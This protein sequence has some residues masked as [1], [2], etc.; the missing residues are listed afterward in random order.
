MKHRKKRVFLIIHKKTLFYLMILFLAGAGL[1]IGIRFQMNSNVPVMGEASTII[2]RLLS[3][4]NA[5]V[6][7]RVAIIIDDF[8][9]SGNGTKEMTEINQ[10]LTCA[11]IP[12]LPYTKQDAELAHNGGHEVI[13]HIPMEPHIG[14]PKW[15]GEK[16]ITSR[17][18]SEQIQQI[19]RE[20]IEEVPYAV[21]VNNHMGSKATEDKRVIEAIV[22]VLKEKNMYIVD[23]KTS[24]NSVIRE[25]AEEYDVPVL[26]RAIFLD[27]EKSI[28]A[29]K[30]QLKLLGE[31]AL[32]EDS[33]IAIG[34]VG[35][36]GGSITAIAIKEM[37][38]VFEEM[39]IKIVPVSQ[40]INLK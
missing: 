31:I 35:P 19:V 29:I 39:G 25:I 16:G 10:P 18:T 8:G 12:F 38:P 7:G 21:G 33:A 15:L 27:N 34:H 4:K 24:M 9:N 32:K 30:K 17:L 23:S 14:N 36:E 5:D 3:K 26:E 6:K 28:T 11:I 13:I 2:D 22:T 20:A 40:L 1:I 37:I